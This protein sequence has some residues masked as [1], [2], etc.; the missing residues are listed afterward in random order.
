MSK[1]AQNSQN[2]LSGI[3]VGVGILIVGLILAFW[4]QDVLGVVTPF[5]AGACLF[6]GV[7]GSVIELA[8][9]I[10]AKILGWDNAGLGIVLAVPALWILLSS[11]GWNAWI[12]Y[13]LNSVAVFVLLLSIA[14]ISD[15]MYKTAKAI[16]NKKFNLETTLKTTG[17]FISLLGS[18]YALA[19]QIGVL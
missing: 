1:K 17:L 4:L 2:S 12:K 7:A 16:A 10:D 14:A 6:I 8:K 13:S 9:V 11:G 5:V 18:L 3:S 19:K 15:G